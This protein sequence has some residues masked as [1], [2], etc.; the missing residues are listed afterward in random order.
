VAKAYFYLNEPMN[1]ALLPK[2]VGNVRYNGFITRE[3]IAELESLAHV[4]VEPG[5][6]IEI[7]GDT[8]VLY[9]DIS[10][11]EQG[12]LMQGIASWVW[13]RYVLERNTCDITL[14]DVFHYMTARLMQ[15]H[16]SVRQWDNNLVIHPLAVKT[17]FESLKVTRMGF[18]MYISLLESAPETAKP[19]LTASQGTTVRFVG[20]VM[21]IEYTP[22]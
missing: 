12:G 10:R 5:R 3:A 13:L 1:N 20:R 9:V 19:K 16:D 8:T 14:D 22:E 11:S 18:N 7:G 2:I 4:V 17:A 21:V 6:S 15:G